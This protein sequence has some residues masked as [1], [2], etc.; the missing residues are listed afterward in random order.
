MQDQ[1]ATLA[2][3]VDTFK[4]DGGMPAPAPRAPA[5][6]TPAVAVRASARPSIAPKTPKVPARIPAPGRLPATAKL[7]P[8]HSGSQSDDW[9]E[10]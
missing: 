6:K 4:V 5:V 9:E 1:A 8:A 10:F 7:E 3:M 2:Q